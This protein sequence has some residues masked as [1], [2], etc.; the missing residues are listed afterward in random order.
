MYRIK[1]MS[2]GF[3]YTISFKKAVKLMYN[4]LANLFI[5]TLSTIIFKK[6]KHNIV[7]GDSKVFMLS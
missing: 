2:L 3:F 7:M 1:H 5:K 6:F 4:K